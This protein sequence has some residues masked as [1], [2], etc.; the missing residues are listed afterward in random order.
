M[1]SFYL[2]FKAPVPGKKK[3]K[4]REK[5]NHKS[6]RINAHTQYMSLNACDAYYCVRV[7]CV[8]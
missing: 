4:R 5:K 6:T 2:R 8:V 7:E 1:V 3:I